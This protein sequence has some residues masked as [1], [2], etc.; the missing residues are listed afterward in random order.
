MPGY[1]N[2]PSA[3]KRLYGLKESQAYLIEA[4]DKAFPIESFPL[5]E[6]AAVRKAC[7]VS[8]DVE[9][10]LDLQALNIPPVL[11]DI[12]ECG[13]SCNPEYSP[14][15]TSRSGWLMYATTWLVGCG[16]PEAQIMGI[17]LNPLWSISETVLDCKGYS[18]EAY[19]RRQVP[20][21]KAHVRAETLEVFEDDFEAEYTEVDFSKDYDHEG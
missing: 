1:V 2:R 20:R 6:I 21:A 9:E 10:V 14:A 17:L 15:D 18:P 11:R 19:A 7:E 16:V 4:N 12:I 5:A 13:E 8:A 3:Q